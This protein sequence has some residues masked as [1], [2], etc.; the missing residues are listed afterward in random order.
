L[1]GIV[2]A[3]FAM[4]GMRFGDWIVRFIDREFFRKLV[5]CGLFV[6]GFNIFLRGLG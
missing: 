5:L 6:L 3:L 2:C 1:L 4:A